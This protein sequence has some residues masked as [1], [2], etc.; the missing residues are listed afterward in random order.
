MSFTVRAPIRIFTPWWLLPTFLNQCR[1]DVK[2]WGLATSISTVPSLSFIGMCILVRPATAFKNPQGI[3]NIF[4][5]RSRRILRALLVHPYQPYRLE[6]L[7]SD[8]K[9]SVGQVSQVL[10]VFRITA[11]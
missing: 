7:A 3:K 9:L 10:V 4:S 6:Q 11:S 5:G 1:P 8:T 2:N